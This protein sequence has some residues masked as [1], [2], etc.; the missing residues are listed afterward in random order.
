MYAVRVVP[1]IL[2]AFA[3]AL[4]AFSYWGLFTEAGQHVFDEMDGLYPLYAGGHA[5][6]ALL[7]FFAWRFGVPITRAPYSRT[8]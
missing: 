5:I 4:G 2:L 8:S 7:L 6:V 1:Q 3:I